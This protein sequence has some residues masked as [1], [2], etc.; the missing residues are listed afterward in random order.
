MHQIFNVVNERSDE[1]EGNIGMTHVDK[2]KFG[3]NSLS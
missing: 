2:V 1:E 3:G